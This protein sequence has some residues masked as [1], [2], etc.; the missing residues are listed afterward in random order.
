L[1]QIIVS[2]GHDADEVMC[3]LARRIRERDIVVTAAP[4]VPRLDLARD[5]PIASVTIG[6]RRHRMI[7]DEDSSPA[8]NDLTR[9]SDARDLEYAF[10]PLG[11]CVQGKSFAW[12]AGENIRVAAG[13]RHIRGGLQRL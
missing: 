13:H 8:Q 6:T 7:A 4:V 1:W 3:G 2:R 5:G 9:S 10:S 11:R 12:P